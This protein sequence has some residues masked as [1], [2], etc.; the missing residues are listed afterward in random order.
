[1]R[2]MEIFDMVAQWTIIIYSSCPKTFPAN[3]C[4]YLEVQD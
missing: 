2:D 1:M 4:M 3:A